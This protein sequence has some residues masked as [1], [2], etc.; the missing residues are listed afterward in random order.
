MLSD[1]IDGKDGI[2]FGLYGVKA[3]F[4]L[5]GATKISSCQINSEFRGLKL[6]YSSRNVLSG[7]NTRKLGLFRV[8]R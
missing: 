1:I 8:N 3:S 7:V 6:A 5:L 2:Y 4:F